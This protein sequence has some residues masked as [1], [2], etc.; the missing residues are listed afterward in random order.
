METTTTKPD[1]KR[2][3]IPTR[4]TFSDS[5]IA[6]L[7]KKGVQFARAYESL[8]KDFT[9]IKADYKL[10]LTNLE[11]ERDR[12]DEKIADGFEMRPT[13]CET[14]FNDPERGKKTTRKLCGEIVS[15]EAMSHFDL[16]KELI[17]KDETKVLPD[18]LNL[19]VTSI[20]IIPASQMLGTNL[21][22]ALG[23]AAA[24]TDQPQVLIPEFNSPDWGAKTLRSHFKKA[25]EKAG[26]P[27][28]A[29]KT[30]LAQCGG[31]DMP[32]IR[33]TMAPHVKGIYV[34]SV[35][36]E[37]VGR[38]TLQVDYQE[39]WGE[40][41]GTHHL[42]VWGMIEPLGQVTT[43]FPEAWDERERLTHLS[44]QLSNAAIANNWPDVAK[45]YLAHCIEGAPL[46][47]L[48]ALAERLAGR[49]K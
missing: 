19:D 43:D 18:D 30:L 23:A 11:N 22:D 7:A 33:A 17:P 28:V 36:V 10:R 38:A 32:A 42:S 24:S 45:T 49:A 40:F 29:I 2:V 48:V 3:N 15:V 41:D 16:E 5:E 26:W 9:S 14:T 39:R 47:D 6:E 8:E 12:L 21:G 31:N 25:A 37:G 13:D 27:E 1:T 34:T 46:A 35:E 44:S 20:T 4:Y